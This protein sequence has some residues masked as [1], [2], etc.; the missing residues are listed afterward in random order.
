MWGENRTFFAGYLWWARIFIGFVKLR[1]S[2]SLIVLSVEEVTICCSYL[3][4]SKLSISL[5]WALWLEMLGLGKVWSHNLSSPSPP[6]E[7]KTFSEVGCHWTWLQ[8]FMCAGKVNRSFPFYV[9]PTWTTPFKRPAMN[10]GFLYAHSTETTYDLPGIAQVFAAPIC[11]KD[12]SPL[13]EP[14]SKNLSFS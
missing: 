10:N 9:V 4:K 8:F 6:H 12:I 5:S 3:L 7:A 14:K 1:K 13:P 2:H 11:Q